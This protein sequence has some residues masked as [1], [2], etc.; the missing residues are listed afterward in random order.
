MSNGIGHFCVR[1]VVTLPRE[2]SILEAATLM[3]KH[4]IGAVLVIDRVDDGVIPAGLLTDRDIVVE[5]VA[6]GL[7][8]G[9]VK[10]GELVQR[11]VTTVHE[12][13]GYADT[14]RL[15]SI[16]GVRRMP[17]VDAKGRLVGI[18]TF[19]DILRQLAAPLLALSDLAVRERHYETETRP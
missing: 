3:R 8:P 11:P 18:I 4:H 6:A 5:I 15:M 19:D 17:V 12:D 10:V 7:E 2:A 13:A 14:V 9:A 16:N 1:N